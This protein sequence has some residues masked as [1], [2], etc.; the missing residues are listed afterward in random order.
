MK[1]AIKTTKEDWA[2]FLWC[3][4]LDGGMVIECV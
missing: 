3:S 4:S 2:E 1:E